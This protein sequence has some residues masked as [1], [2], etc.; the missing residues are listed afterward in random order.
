MGAGCGCAEVTS[1]EGEGDEGVTTKVGADNYGGVAS[2][3]GTGFR[4]G[5]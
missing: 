4:V 1:G 5:C 3:P 2:E